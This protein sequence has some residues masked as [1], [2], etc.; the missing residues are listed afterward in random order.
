MLG[1]GGCLTMFDR[2]EG[3]HVLVEGILLVLIHSVCVA[4]PIL[5]CVEKHV[6]IRMYVLSIFP[7]CTFHMSLDNWHLENGLTVFCTAFRVVGLAASNV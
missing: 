7:A 5:P 4:L 6:H 2:K 3:S 1:P